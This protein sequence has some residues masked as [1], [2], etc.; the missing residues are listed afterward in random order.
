MANGF[1]DLG[2]GQ[3]SKTMPIL[4][5]TYL[6]SKLQLSSREWTDLKISLVEF[7]ILPSKDE[8]RIYA[9]TFVPRPIS[10]ENGVFFEVDEAIQMTL[11]RLPVAIKNKLA[12]ELDD[13]TKIWARFAG[14]LDTSGGHRV[15]NS[16]ATL[17]D[18]IVTTHMFFLGFTLIS[19]KLY[20][21][22]QAYFL[23]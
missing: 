5:A 11:N 14:G 2:K 18:D 17:K 6:K 15:Y 23:L 9:N 16:K 4:K 21:G 19:L 8:L 12:E 1:H 10:K 13:G 22:S 3:F 7:V 20:D